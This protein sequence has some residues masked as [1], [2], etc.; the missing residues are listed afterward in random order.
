MPWYFLGNSPRLLSQMLLLLKALQAS[1]LHHITTT[2]T[3]RQSCSFSQVC[4][5]MFSY[6]SVRKK[7][8]RDSMRYNKT[9]LP[10]PQR[11]PL[12]IN[13]NLTCQNRSRWLDPAPQFSLLS[14]FFFFAPPEGSIPIVSL[15]NSF[16]AYYSSRSTPEVSHNSL[17]ISLFSCRIRGGVHSGIRQSGLAAG[18]EFIHSSAMWSVPSLQPRFGSREVAV[19]ALGNYF[20]PWNCVTCMDLAVST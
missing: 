4:C 18:H 17:L 12:T 14:L 20:I 1:S 5:G 15:Y 16:L 6:F 19:A 11:F 2:C 8:I 7:K 13:Y 9:N 10:L 3:N